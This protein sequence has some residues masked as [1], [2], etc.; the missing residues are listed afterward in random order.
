VSVLAAWVSSASEDVRLLTNAFLPE[1]LLITVLV[2]LMFGVRKVFERDH[3]SS[4]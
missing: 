4:R 1:F 2:V 3:R